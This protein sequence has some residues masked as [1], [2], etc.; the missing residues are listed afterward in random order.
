VREHVD[1]A[2]RDGQTFSV[3]DCCCGSTAQI[4]NGGDSITLDSHIGSDW[5]TTSSV[6]NRTAANDE[7]ELLL[8]IRHNRQRKD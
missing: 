4:S 2:R 8:S 1:K 6:V 7:V 3:N 5:R